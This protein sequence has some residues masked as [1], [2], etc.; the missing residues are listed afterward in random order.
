[1]TGIESWTGERLETFVFNENTIEHLHRYVIAAELAAGKTVLDIA[2]GE[3]YGTNMIAGVA[4]E[5]V[6]VDIDAETIANAQNKYRK[7]N[8]SFKT[9][10]ADQ[11]PCESGYFDLVVSFET[12][13]HH[14]RHHEMMAEIKRVLKPGGILLISSPDKKYYS[15]AT[16]YKNPYHVKELYQQEFEELLSQY[17]KHTSYCRQKNFI[18]SLVIPRFDHTE[19]DLVTMYNGDYDGIGNND[20]GAQ[21]LVALASDN[22]LPQLKLTLF[23]GQQVVQKQID[24]VRDQVMAFMQQQATD[25]FG[26]MQK[27]AADHIELLRQQALND[28]EQARQNEALRLRNTRDYRMGNF[29]LSPLRT[30]KKIF[31]A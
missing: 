11:I 21:F 1:M 12:I 17:F 7:D 13:E 10:S 23:D 27:E 16:G 2:S 6:G 4:A 9:G 19:N 22:E 15:D 31:Y 14:D 18:G 3:G 8:L 20:V 26:K 24:D 25:Y 5:V 28:I 30:I 29:L